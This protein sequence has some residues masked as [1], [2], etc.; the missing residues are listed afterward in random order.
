MRE[1]KFRAWEPYQRELHYFDNLKASNDQFIAENLLSLMA[2]KHYLGED[3][4]MQ[5]TGL[6]DKNGVEIYEMDIVRINTLNEMIAEVT[7]ENGAFG[8]LQKNNS[9]WHPKWNEHIVAKELIK[10]KLTVEVIGNIYQNPELL[11]KE[12]EDENICHRIYKTI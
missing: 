1:I 12:Q 8:Y 11:E 4:L 2:N 9:F 10:N 5:Y 7:F 3:L 6:K